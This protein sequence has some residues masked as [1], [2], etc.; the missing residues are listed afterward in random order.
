MSRTHRKHESMGRASKRGPKNKTSD[1]LP[2][3][4]RKSSKQRRPNERT[5]L[6]KD[7]L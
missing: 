6:R 7:Y 4:V 1:D 3:E 5:R 2:P